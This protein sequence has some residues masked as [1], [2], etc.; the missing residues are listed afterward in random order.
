[1]I[2]LDA[3]LPELLEG[4]HAANAHFMEYLLHNVRERSLP[5]PGLP[6]HSEAQ[7]LGEFK[8]VLVCHISEGLQDTFI[9]TL[10]ACVGQ[11][12]GHCLVKELP[13]GVP[14]EF[15]HRFPL[16]TER[17]HVAM[18]SVLSHRGHL[19]CF[20]RSFIISVKPLAQLSRGFYADYRA[21]FHLAAASAGLNNSQSSL[22]SS[23][24]TKL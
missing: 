11:D 13:T 17:G 9:S 21:Q 14:A 19:S 10:K 12:C 2:V 6:I 15:R 7:Q 22:S 5:Q 8:A 16:P 18:L 3:V 1:M 4:E 23:K 20:P 24:Y